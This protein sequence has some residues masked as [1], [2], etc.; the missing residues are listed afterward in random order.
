MLHVSLSHSTSI[1]FYSS[2]LILLYSRVVSLSSLFHRCRIS[3]RVTVCLFN[4]NWHWNTAYWRGNRICCDCESR[5]RAPYKTCNDVKPHRQRRC[6]F[7]VMRR[8]RNVLYSARAAIT[9]LGRSVAIC[10]HK[11]NHNVFD[12]FRGWWVEGLFTYMC[13]PFTKQCKGDNAS[14]LRKLT[15]VLRR[16]YDNPETARSAASPTLHLRLCDFLWK[17]IHYECIWSPRSVSVATCILA[18]A[19]ECWRPGVVVSALASI[20]EVNLR[21]AWL[22]LR[23]ATVSGFS[24]RWRKFISVYNQPATQGQLSLPSLRGR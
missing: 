23:W 11:C 14:M 3:S 2:F 12:V 19:D 7:A 16:V 17:Y 1:S 18:L 6:R 5:S 9:A 21:R 8:C 24:S 4:I 22:V 13:L 15:A 10:N 20:N